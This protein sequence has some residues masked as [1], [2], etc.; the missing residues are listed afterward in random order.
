MPQHPAPAGW[1]R[2]PSRRHAAR[3]WD[4]SRW[5][6]SARDGNHIVQ[7][8]LAGDFSP[9]PYVPPGVE[10]RQLPSR[11]DFFD[12]C[13]RVAWRTGP[14]L[15]GLTI[16][17]VEAWFTAKR[18]CEQGFIPTQWLEAAAIGDA[19]KRPRRL[20]WNETHLP[21]HS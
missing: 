16:G 13:L 4:G 19:R 7:D 15:P 11:P 5:S 12:E 2:D 14:P 8:S 1:Y 3:Y 21:G 17:V 18:W 6:Q 20:A 10:G 9:P